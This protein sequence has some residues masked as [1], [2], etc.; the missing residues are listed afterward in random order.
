MYGDLER[1]DDIV[2][3][4]EGVTNEDEP[5]TF[6]LTQR[7]IALRELG[8]HDAS[9]EAFKE[10]LRLRSRP[11]ELRHRALVERAGTYLAQGKAGMARKDLEKVY[12][13]NSKYPGLREALAEL[14]E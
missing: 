8:M 2:D 13:E 14:P 11:V 3:L 5:S 1:W 4:T 7:G 6:L 12:A 10:A 9:R